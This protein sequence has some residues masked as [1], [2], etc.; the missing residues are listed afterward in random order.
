M[1]CWV[2]AAGSITSQRLKVGGGGDGG[3]FVCLKCSNIKVKSLG[4]CGLGLPSGFFKTKI[5]WK[6]L[7][8]KMYEM[9][10]LLSKLSTASLLIL[11]SHGVLM[12]LTDALLYR[13]A[14]AHSHTLILI[15][16]WATGLFFNQ[17]KLA[18]WTQCQNKRWTGGDE[19]VLV[20]CF[21][22]NMA[23]TKTKRR[24]VFTR[25]RSHRW[26]WASPASA[27]VCAQ[28]LLNVYVCLPSSA[29]DRQVG[30]WDVRELGKTLEGGN[31]FRNKLGSV[32]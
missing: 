8:A 11:N 6:F 1:M 4:R 27:A 31:I 15:T 16:F 9:Q 19:R 17:A 26:I 5:K 24:G 10:S 3:T 30:G 14:K 22:S 2:S 25:S 18:G 20:M 13:P 23:G 29:G 21:L 12:H 7:Y 28:Q 32:S